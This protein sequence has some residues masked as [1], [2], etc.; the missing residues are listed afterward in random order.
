M[1]TLRDLR[2]G[3]LFR[4]TDEH[5]ENVR[6]VLDGETKTNAFVRCVDRPEYSGWINEITETKPV[7]RVVG[8]FVD[9]PLPKSRTVELTAKVYDKGAHSYAML[10]AD[11]KCTNHSGPSGQAKDVVEWVR[12]TQGIEPELVTV[13]LGG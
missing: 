1:T 3:D 8:T 7:V 2:Q 6:L 10:F 12:Q 11:N 13:V 9:A 5:A 4:F